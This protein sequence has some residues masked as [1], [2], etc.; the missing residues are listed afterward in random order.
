LEI[1]NMDIKSSFSFAAVTPEKWEDFEALFGARGACGGCWCMHWRLNSKDFEEGKGE[2]NRNSMK[3]MILSGKKPGILVYNGDEPVA[4][5]SVS[6][7]E[8][9]VY[10]KTSRT[11]KPVD[12]KKVWAITCLFTRKEYRRKGL[13]TAILGFVQEH[14]KNEGGKIIEAYPFDLQGQELP[15]SFVWKGLYQSYIKAG[16]K[17][18]ARRSGKRPIVRYYL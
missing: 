6:P 11:F 2:Q 8:N 1:K 16:F 3:K 13:T 5:C 10:F 7:R 18:I 15:D 9:F 12:D 17:E 14:V 4:W